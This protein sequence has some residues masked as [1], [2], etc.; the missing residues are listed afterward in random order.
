MYHVPRSRAWVVTGGSTGRCGSA[1]NFEP[2]RVNA[3]NNVARSFILPCWAL[4][5]QIVLAI[6]RPST[7]SEIPNGG[8][9]GIAFRTLPA[10]WLCCELP[11][12]VSWVS[13]PCVDG[14]RA[15]GVCAWEPVPTSAWACCFWKILTFRLLSSELSS[16]RD[17]ISDRCAPIVRSCSTTRNDIKP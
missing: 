14:I 6:L 8:R 12:G 10:L 1:A 11:A 16:S 2:G 4:Q 17:L 5:T 13:G 15:E 3:K 9:C 7:I